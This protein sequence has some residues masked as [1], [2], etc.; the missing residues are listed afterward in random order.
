MPEKEHG[1]AGNHHGTQTNQDE[2]RSFL[3]L[4]ILAHYST[5]KADGGAAVAISTIKAQLDKNGIEISVSGLRAA[6]D[7]ILESHKWF[8]L[9]W[10]DDS[11]EKLAPVAGVR[12]FCRS[13][14]YDAL[15]RNR[16]RYQ[17]LTNLFAEIAQHIGD[18]FT[19]PRMLVDAGS[20]TFH[21]LF[22]DRCQKLR[23]KVDRLFT[24]NLFVALRYQED[25]QD[26]GRIHLI[27]G[28]PNLETAA[29]VENEKLKQWLGATSR[30]PDVSLLS[31]HYVEHSKGDVLLHTK[32]KRESEMKRAAMEVTQGIIYVVWSKDKITGRAPSGGDAYSINEIIKSQSADDHRER[33][34][35]LITDMES[36]ADKTQEDVVAVLRNRELEKHRIYYRDRSSVD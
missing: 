23:K 12:W 13:S 20:T 28:V 25:C 24:N 8:G 21:C 15:I 17:E 35:Y 33:E 14:M 26:L 31:W 7:E 10:T 4:G 34:V 36:P 2:R 5:A 30:K 29:T 22:H 9:A 18:R 32:D 16:P 3:I 11:K 6:I 1:A 19:Q 27:G